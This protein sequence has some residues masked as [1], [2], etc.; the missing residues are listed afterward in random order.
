MQTFEPFLANQIANILGMPF[1]EVKISEYENIL[2][3]S[4]W[5][6][7]PKKGIVLD[8]LLKSKFEN[9]DKPPSNILLFIDEPDKGLE[10]GDHGFT[11]PL[12]NAINTFLHTTLETGTTEYSIQ[13]Y[14]GAHHTI[15]RVV[16][17]LG[18]NK[19]FTEVLGKK[20]ARALETR[21]QTIKLPG[22]NAAQKRSIVGKFIEQNKEELK[23]GFVQPDEGMITRIIETDEKLEFKG[24][25]VLRHVVRSYINSEANKEAVRFALGKEPSPFS[26]DEA[27]KGFVQTEDPLV[28][29]EDREVQT[30]D[31]LEEPLPYYY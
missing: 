1:C 13:H 5:S 26:I 18:A 4:L 21:V 20:D 29:K 19:T 17:V 9:P 22:Y 28:K 12:G 3:N 31:S 15:M 23:E 25:R 11:H 27:Y 14:D 6:N 30:E 10:K 8:A 7:D 16:I 2:G 24:V